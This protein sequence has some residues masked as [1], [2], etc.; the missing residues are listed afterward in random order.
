MIAS[1][2]KQSNEI[3]YAHSE[4]SEFHQ[5]LRVPLNVI[6]RVMLRKSYARHSISSFVFFLG[7]EQIS[8][9]YPRNIRDAC[10]F[11][12]TLLG[13][14]VSEPCS[15]VR[16][17]TSNNIL[18]PIILKYQIKAFLPNVALTSNTLHS[19]T[20]FFVFVVCFVFNLVPLHSLKFFFLFSRIRFYIL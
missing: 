2:H 9:F 13:A 16:K 3:F 18:L 10:C 4:S 14:Y 5:I 19:S 12:Q 11:L 15:T 20:V 8:N 1:G 17:V 6:I 7:Q